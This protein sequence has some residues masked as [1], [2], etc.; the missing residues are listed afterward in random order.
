MTLYRNGGTGGK[1][2]SQINELT[3]GMTETRI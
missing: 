1:A 3:M 2:N